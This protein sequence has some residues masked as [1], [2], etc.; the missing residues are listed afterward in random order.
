MAIK[1]LFGKQSGKSANITLDQIGSEIES[2]NL[3]EVILKE[4]NRFSLNIDYSKPENFAKFGS[5]K[6]YYNDSIRNIYKTYP[7]DGSNYEKTSWHLSASELTNWIFDNHYPRTSGFINF[8]KSYGATS[9]ISNG[10]SN[11]DKIEYIHFK[12]R[13]SYRLFCF[14]N[15]KL[16]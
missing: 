12:G 4:K 10:Y 3:A 11:P 1:D 9:S 16:I 6:Q 14:G 8:G 15:K 5:A 2:V 13:S 7:Y